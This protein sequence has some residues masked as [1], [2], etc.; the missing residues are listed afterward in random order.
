[1]ASLTLTIPNANVDEVTTAF[2]YQVNVRNEAGELVPNPQTRLEFM[3]ATFIKII[4]DNVKTL[5]ATKAEQ[6]AK[7]VA[8]TSVDTGAT[9]LSIT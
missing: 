3:K 1:M 6:D 7:I 4:K 2:G 5:R 8:T 9:S